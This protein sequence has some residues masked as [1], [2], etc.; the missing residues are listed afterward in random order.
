[1]KSDRKCASL[2]QNLF[3]LHIFFSLSFAP[4]TSTS[5]FITK[6][7]IQN[8]YIAHIFGIDIS[9]LTEKH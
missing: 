3:I 1:M 7:N 5:A 9:N 6:F 8:H 2:L 4:D